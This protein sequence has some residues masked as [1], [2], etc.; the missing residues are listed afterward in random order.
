[1]RQSLSKFWLVTCMC[2]A[3]L[4]TALFMQ[5]A[6]AA[7][8]DPERPVR[9]AYIEG[10]PYI[11]YQLILISLAHGLA[12]LGVLENG[13]VPV[14][15]DT[16]STAGVWQ[17]LC[18]NAGGDLIEF[19]PDA[20]YTADWDDDLFA[21]KHAELLDRLNSTT[22]I[23]LV[24]AFG[25]LA[26]QAMAS[27]EHQTPVAVLSVT[28]AVTA[29]IIPSPDDSGRDHIFAMIEPNRYYR[30]VVLFHDIFQFSRLGIAYEDTAQG[31]ASAALSQIE[32]AAQDLDFELTT[33]TNTFNFVT[34][35]PATENLIA[36]HEQLAEAGVDAVYITV[37][38][39]MQE[40]DMPELLRP[41]LD[42]RLPTFS[43]NGVTEVRHG[44]LLSISQVNFSGQGLFAA[45]AIQ[46]IIS[47]ESPRAQ[48]QKYEEPLSLAV[49]LHT[50]MLI[51][52]NPSLAV[53]AAVDEI[54]QGQ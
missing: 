12:E 25:T 45:R 11:D 5:P 54:F 39:G 6:Q 48:N 51:G 50:A 23:D 36:C 28:D 20:Y 41:L 2:S 17:W 1:M 22:D 4:L 21:Q 26:G 34:P 30:E 49:N 10:G 8:G 47:G 37:N 27:D 18:D 29:G 16:E 53:L 43:Q 14:P 19:V 52:W 7:P 33:C 46:N 44:V 24:L 38:M 13:N 35:E 40:Q 31:R 42:K 3:V 9:V 15:E 32:Q